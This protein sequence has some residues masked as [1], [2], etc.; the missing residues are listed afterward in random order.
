MPQLLLE[1]SLLSLY[2]N[3][4]ENWF[5]TLKREHGEDWH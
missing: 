3:W 4:S 5:L 1:V 2:I